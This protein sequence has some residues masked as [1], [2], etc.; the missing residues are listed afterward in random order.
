MRLGDRL[1]YNRATAQGAVNGGAGVS[2]G[3]K[4]HVKFYAEARYHR[5]FLGNDRH[6]D[7]LP[8]TFGFRW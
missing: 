7:L 8:V 6:A 2:F 5:M 4:W 1:G 3:T